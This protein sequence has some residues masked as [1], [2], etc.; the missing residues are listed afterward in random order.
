MVF[1]TTVQTV[2]LNYVG[3]ETHVCWTL[4]NT[5]RKFSCVDKIVTHI[6]GEKNDHSH[7][8]IQNFSMQI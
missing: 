4:H 2:V 3:F 7:K 8:K 6:A 5:S 1:E